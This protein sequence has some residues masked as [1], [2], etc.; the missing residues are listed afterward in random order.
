MARALVLGVGNILMQDEGVG[1]RTLEWLQSHYAFP[2]E[3]E[4]NVGQANSLSND[5]IILLDGG[6][7][8][9]SLLYYFAGVDHLIILDAVE[10]GKSP[11]AIIELP[12]D[13]IPTFISLKLSPHQ[14]GVQ[15]LLATAQLL[16]YTPPEVTI[17]GVQ[18]AWLSVGLDMSPVVAAQ[19][20]PLA[21][22]ALV[23]LQRWGYLVKRQP[24]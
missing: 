7:M 18:P 12:E 22:L 14:V 11:G 2:G 10:A 3:V 20:E 15:D 8:G 17:L 24:Q 16:G 6:T 4:N 21:H 13:A 19:V 5:E 23:Q 1:I 9:L